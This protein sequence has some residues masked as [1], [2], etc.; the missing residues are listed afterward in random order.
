M[1]CFSYYI[2]RREGAVQALP[3]LGCE[4]GQWACGPDRSQPP[5]EEAWMYRFPGCWNPSLPKGLLHVWAWSSE[6][7]APSIRQ[8]W[9]PIRNS[10]SIAFCLRT[11]TELCLL[12]EK[13]TQSDTR[14]T[15][16]LDYSRYCH[17]RR[18]T[19]A[20]IC[21]LS[22]LESGVGIS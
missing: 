1:G 22:T 17:H 15:G 5:G 20:H 4:S 9:G 3:L 12:L 8:G 6:M 21:C 11:N 13:S 7:Y 14:Y 10:R 18:E 19:M 2:R 16:A